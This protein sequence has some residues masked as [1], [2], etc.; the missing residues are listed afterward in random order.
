MDLKSALVSYVLPVI[1][2]LV[3]AF[4]CSQGSGKNRLCNQQYALC[5][6]ARCVPDPHD[7]N[8]STCFCDVEEG[9]TMSTVPCDKIMPS[10][11]A[12][13]IR[14]IYSTFSFQQLKQ[15]KR[16]MR[17]PS[18]TPWSWC[19]NKKCTVDPTNSKRAICTCDVLRSVGEWTTFGGNCDTRT[20]ATGYWSGASLDDDASATSFLTKALGLNQSPMKWCKASNP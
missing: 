14:T 9:P 16:G 19:L 7:A 8:K 4:G 13:G 2:V 12:F 6:S 3:I 5:T 15:G 11:D 10:T 17:C 20:C 1:A 18:D